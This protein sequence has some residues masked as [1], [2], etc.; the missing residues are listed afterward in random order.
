MRRVIAEAG[1]DPATVLTPEELEYVYDEADTVL[2][3]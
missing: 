1:V 3:R 2:S